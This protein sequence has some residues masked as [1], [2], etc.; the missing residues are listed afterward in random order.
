MTQSEWAAQQA[1]NG[2]AARSWGR[3]L[4]PGPIAPYSDDEGWQFRGRRKRQSDAAPAA[5]GPEAAASGDPNQFAPLANL[6][7]WKRLDGT[8]KSGGVQSRIKHHNKWLE[9]KQEAAEKLQNGGGEL[10]E[11]Q[12]P[13]QQPP[14]QQ[15]Q[16][17]PGS[18][19]SFSS[20]DIEGKPDRRGERR[21][22]RK[23]RGG[24]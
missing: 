19:S 9:K 11:A 10:Q 2:G 1:G 20:G 15:P 6:E 17:Q 5:A 22:Q 3:P 14:P 18:P 24:R 13:P 7:P 23:P 12:P 16:E 21:E 4:D 8:K